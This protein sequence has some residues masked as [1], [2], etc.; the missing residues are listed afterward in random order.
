VA[1]SRNILIYEEYDLLT[2]C[3]QVEFHRIFWGT[4]YLHLQDYPVW[5]WRCSWRKI[6][7]PG[8]VFHGNKWRL[9]RPH[10]QSPTLHSRCGINKGL[11]KMGSTIGHWRSRC[12]GW[13]LWPTPYTYIHTYIFR[14]E[15]DWGNTFL[16][17]ISGLLR[18]RTVLNTRRQNILW[19]LLW[20]PQIQRVSYLQVP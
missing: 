15:K 1:G 16:R 4:Y 3:C 18:D 7:S 11:I 14:I 17:N 12:K 19:S 13:F 20:Q 6:S 9:W 2:L 5:L 10:I 8:P